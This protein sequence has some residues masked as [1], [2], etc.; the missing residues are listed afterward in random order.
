MPKQ[1]TQNCARA[2]AAETEG[3]TVLVV[4]GVLVDRDSDTGSCTRTKKRPDGSA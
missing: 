2:G 1:P 4:A 3:N